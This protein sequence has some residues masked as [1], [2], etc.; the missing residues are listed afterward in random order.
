M[1]EISPS[2]RHELMKISEGCTNCGLCE[3]EC[4]FLEKY[5]SPKE[6]A[7]RYTPEDITG[8]AMAF[9]CSLC[10]LCASVCP[11]KVDPGVMFLEMRREAVRYGCGDFPEHKTILGYERRGTSK[12]YSYYALPDSCST[13]FFPGCV[14]P[15][16][17][18]DK[19]LAIYQELRK[20][21][22][23]LGIVLDCCTKP[24]H[25]LGR[26]LYFNEMFNE[27]RG[28][29]VHNGVQKILVACPSCYKVFD[30]YGQDLTVEIVYEHIAPDLLSNGSTIKGCVTVQ[31]PCVTRYDEHIQTAVRRLISS[32]GLT[33]KEMDHHGRNTICCGEGGAAGFVAP[34]FAGEWGEIR[35]KESGTNRII[36]YCAGCSYYL[37]KATQTSHILDVL[38]EPEA[39]MAG[40]VRASRAPFTYLNRLR[41]K[42]RLKQLVKPSVTRERDFT[43]QETKKDNGMLKKILPLVLIIC[44]IS[45]IHLTGAIE[46]LDQD[47]LRAWISGYG[48]LAPFIY[49]LIYTITPALFFPGLPLTVIGGILFGPIWGVVYTIIGA[50]AGACLAFLISRYLTRDW[51]EAKL[52]KSRWRELDQ[53]VEQHGWKVV[54]L[55]RLV[56]LFPFNLLNYAFGLTKIRFVHYAV[57]SFVCMLPATI[58]FIVFSSSLLDLVKG[59]VSWTFLTGILLVI[60]VSLIP[61]IYRKRKL[62]EIE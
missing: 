17:R 57:V 26:D 36:T 19:T 37:D 59:E 58:A 30:R 31:D 2:F 41:L 42:R 11:V 25:D 51:I 38:F 18:P 6:I 50:T 22:P 62:K 13:V 48:V 40:K 23:S 8:T 21:E 16:T 32:K 52:K 20:A 9:E 46:Y 45:A 60:I 4:A 10:G 7:D 47:R 1:T 61:V 29:L 27:M 5:G 49:M 55:T 34:D 12:L 39:A 15:G 54:A 33:V 24:S 14:L 28:Y 56:P 35:R 43:A 3:K 44:A 53:K